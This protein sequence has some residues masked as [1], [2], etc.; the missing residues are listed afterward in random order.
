MS[1]H[2][3]LAPHTVCFLSSGALAL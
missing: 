3:G 2:I 1:M